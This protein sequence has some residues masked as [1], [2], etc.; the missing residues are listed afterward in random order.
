MEASSNRLK[1][2]KKSSDVQLSELKGLR[3]VHSTSSQVSQIR[4]AKST[5]ESYEPRV[6]QQTVEG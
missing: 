1:K 2:Q 6:K 5:K 4:Y 3:E